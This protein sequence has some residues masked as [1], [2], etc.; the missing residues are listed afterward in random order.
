[1]RNIVDLGRGDDEERPP[2]DSYIDA[3]NSTSLKNLSNAEKY[4]F[5]STCTL[6]ASPDYMQT[7]KTVTEYWM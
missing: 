7:D 6:I 1:M 2:P 5:V 4:T 3:L